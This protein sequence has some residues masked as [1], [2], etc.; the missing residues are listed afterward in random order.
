MDVAFGAEKRVDDDLACIECLYVRLTVSGDNKQM[1]DEPSMEQVPM[2]SLPSSEISM[3]MTLA[4]C[5]RY[6]FSL[7]PL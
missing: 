4:P 7:T 2:N 3:A 5:A 6:S 1:K